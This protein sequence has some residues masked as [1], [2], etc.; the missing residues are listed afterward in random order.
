[1]KILREVFW[2]NFNLCGFFGKICFLTRKRLWKKFVSSQLKF[3]GREL[4]KLCKEKVFRK[5]EDLLNLSSFLEICPW[6][7][8]LTTVFSWPK[9]AGSTS[10]WNIFPGQW[11]VNAVHY[12]RPNRFDI[13]MYGL[14]KIL[15]KILFDK[16]RCRKTF[17]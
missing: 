12:S 10:L 8:S 14:Y 11:F 4:W 1:M 7:A 16:W 15:L 2:T 3:C 6:K 17:A 13:V 5:S 9:V